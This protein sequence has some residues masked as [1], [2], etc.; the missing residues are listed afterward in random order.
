M[1]FCPR[2]GTSIETAAQFCRACG[3]TLPSPQPGQEQ[4][5][6][7]FPP[8]SFEQ[9]QQ[10]YPPPNYQPPPGY[11]PAPV[12]Y[13]A[14]AG[15]GPAPGVK[16]AGAEKKLAAGLCGILIGSLGIHKFI[17]GYNTEG[18]IMLLVT[19]LTCGLGAIVTSV[20]GIVE[21]IIYLTKSDAD[22]VNIYVLNKKGWF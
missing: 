19:L 8:P 14:Q 10:G 7:N 11:P 18:L 12:G 2:C 21:G 6:G 20:I 9:S 5:Q 15:Y 4:P 1:R 16:P 13:P 3:S 22:F 17:L